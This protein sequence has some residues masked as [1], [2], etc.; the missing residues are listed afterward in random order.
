[1]SKESISKQINNLDIDLQKTKLLVKELTNF[2]TL[3]KTN[4][5][6]IKI[7]DKK[8]FKN[9]LESISNFNDLILDDFFEDSNSLV[10]FYIEDIEPSILYLYNEFIETKI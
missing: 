9:S 7:T 8:T 6:S 10:N 5:K 1:M 3:I 4:E 2:S